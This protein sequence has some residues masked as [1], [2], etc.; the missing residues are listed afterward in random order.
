MIILYTLINNVLIL[1]SD[2]KKKFFSFVNNNILFIVH[3]KLITY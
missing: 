1:S 3:L 2:F